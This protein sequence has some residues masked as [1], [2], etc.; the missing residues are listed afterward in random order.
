MASRA[1]VRVKNVAFL[2]GAP[3]GRELLWERLPAA[4][5]QPRIRD[6]TE[7][8]SIEEFAPMGRSYGDDNLS[9]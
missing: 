5:S 2:V 8:D 3:H 7:W 9:R 4:S 6:P 1:V